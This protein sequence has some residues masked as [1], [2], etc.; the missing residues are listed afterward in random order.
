MSD[1][2]LDLFLCEQVYHCR[3]SELDQEDGERIARHMII[4]DV[5]AKVAERK[6][7]K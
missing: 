1:D 7:K 6:R 4:L 2:D 3:P 5:R